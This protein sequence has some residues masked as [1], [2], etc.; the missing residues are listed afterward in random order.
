MNISDLP[1]ELL[2]K[3][4]DHVSRHI[5]FINKYYVCNLRKHFHDVSYLFE[6]I[7][8][9]LLI[10]YEQ[11]KHAYITYN[12]PNNIENLLLKSDN[13][14]SIKYFCNLIKK[15]NKRIIINTHYYH[16][17]EYTYY[18]HNNSY[19][20]DNASRNGNINLLKCLHKNNFNWCEITCYL[21][22]DNGHLNCLKYLCK[23]KCPKF[24]I[25]DLYDLIDQKKCVKYA[26]I[27][28]YECTHQVINHQNLQRY[29]LRE[30]NNCSDFLIKTILK[31]LYLFSY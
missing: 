13:I 1:I 16:M 29:T 5:V 30:E 3:T 23:H 12:M 4:I 18:S 14:V 17:E 21:S 22:I 7:N 6:I 9:K 27:H 24:I 20:C 15:N 31:I 28:G 25:S 19:F 2:E 26:Y 11:Y 10:Y 8:L